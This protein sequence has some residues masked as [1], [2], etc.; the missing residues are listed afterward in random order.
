[1]NQTFDG[2]GRITQSLSGW[3]F[4]YD[5]FDRMVT[6]TRDGVSAAYT[7]WPDGTRRST[8]TEGG[9]AGATHP[10]VPLRHRRQPRQRHHRR[11][12]HRSDRL[13]PGHRRSRSPHPAARHH[14]RRCRPRRGTGPRRHRYRHRLPAARPPLLGH[15]ARRRQ[16][17][18]DEH[19]QLRRLRVAGA[20]PTVA[21][22]RYPPRRRVGWPTRSNMRGRR[23]S[24]R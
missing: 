15:R 8:T 5:A 4:S 21:C 9:A 7:Y 1:M 19:L 11:R 18:G 22:R 13:L 14:H 12:H 2:E 23:R 10:D 3:A 6:A 20:C 17:G 16:R 24:A